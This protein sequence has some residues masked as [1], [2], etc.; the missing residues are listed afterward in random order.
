MFFR[1]LPLLLAA[2]LSATVAVGAEP[3]ER[4]ATVVAR[5]AD[6]PVERKTTLELPGVTAC[7]TC[8]WRPMKKEMAADQCSGAP[9]IFDCG[10]D[11]DCEPKC[12]FLKCAN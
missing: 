6:A 5:E 10:R 12:E 3:A 7:H 8:E 9:G 1:I 2:G 11:T 4:N